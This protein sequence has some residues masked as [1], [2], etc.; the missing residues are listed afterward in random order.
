MYINVIKIA[1]VCSY[2]GI[3]FK[4]KTL[5]CVKTS[6]TVPLSFLKFKRLLLIVTIPNI[7]N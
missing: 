7:V 4:F 1:I 5:S 2:K 3:P 6:A